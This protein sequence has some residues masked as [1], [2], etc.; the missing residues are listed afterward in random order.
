MN[1]KNKLFLRLFLLGI[2]AI[3]NGAFLKLNGNSNADILLSAG[4]I[5]KFTAI[6]GLFINNFSKIKVFFK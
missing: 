2:F 4:L 6:V 1:K 5:F 3:F